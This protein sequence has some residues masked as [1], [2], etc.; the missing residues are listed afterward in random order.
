VALAWVLAQPG[1]TSPILGATRPE[2]VDEA[3]A[4][5]D[6]G[7]TA[8]QMAALEAAYQPRPPRGGGH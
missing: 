2:H 3:V 7:L 4:A 8:E 5:L 1:M 6:L